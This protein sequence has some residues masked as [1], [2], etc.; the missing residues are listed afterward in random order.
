MCAGVYTLP[1]ECG[2][3]CYLTGLH[4]PAVHRPLLTVKQ[5]LTVLFW[6]VFGSVQ[7][8]LLY[9]NCLVSCLNKLV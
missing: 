8:M 7:C 6:L 9:K 4:E 3:R 1:F 2:V 5:Q